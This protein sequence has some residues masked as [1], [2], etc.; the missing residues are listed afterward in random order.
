MKPTQEHFDRARALHAGRI[1]AYRRGELQDGEFR[2]IRLSY[3]LYYQLDHTSY[4]QRIKLPGGFLSSE[5][6]DALAAVIDDY[7]RGV[8]HVT[9]RQDVQIHWVPLERVADMYERLERVGITTRGACADSVRNVTACPFAGVSADEPFDVSP[10]VQA[11]HDYF[12]FNPLNLT[13]PRKFKIAVEGCPI[14][15]AQAT[16]N[17]IGLYAQKRGDRIGFSVWGGG[18]LGAAPFLAVQVADFIAA[19]DV[20]VWCEAIVRIQH[21]SGERKNRHKARLKFLVRKLGPA[22]FAEAVRAEVERVAAERGA[23][24]R[25][26]VREAVRSQRISTPAP[27]RDPVAPQP[28]FAAWARTNA[29]SQRDPE[30]CAVTVTLP[31]GDVDTSQLR[32]LGAIARELGDGTVRATNEQNLVLPW[33]RRAALPELHARLVAI[34]LAQGEASLVTDVVACPGLDYCSLAVTRSMGV[35][36]RIRRHLVEDATDAEAPGPFHVKISGC[37]NSCGQHHIGDV[38]LT[39]MMVKDESGIERPHYSLLLGGAVGEGRTR[40]GKRLVGR[41]SEDDAPRA[42]AALAAFYR[43][44]RTSGERFAEFVERIGSDEL[45]TVARRAAVGEVR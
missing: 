16:I 43:Q 13:L 6:I 17:D 33:V 29:V 14:D 5:Q 2:P 40:I 45:D 39:G 31:L 18:G 3:G 28:G 4:M 20:L 25:E 22:A 30:F 9:T 32:A 34:E 26:E 44:R 7:G 12:L 41:Y 38:G 1:E 36:E 23:E 21:R 35:G 19:E 42:I 37:P 24:L 27:P 15:C 8:T 10:Y 11:I